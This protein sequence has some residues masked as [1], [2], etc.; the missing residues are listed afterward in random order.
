DG[1]R[2]RPCRR[3]IEYAAAPDGGEL[4]PV[5]DERDP[6]TGLVGD[7]EQGSGG[8]LVEHPGFVDE[9][10]VAGPELGARIGSWAR[11]ASP[12]PVGVPAPSVLV[13]QPGGGV[14]V[15]A[16]LEGGDLRRLQ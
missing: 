9:Q 2:V 7:G 11:P 12:V 3:V 8:V 15:G 6:C 4:V 13:D 16:R 14:A 1:G 5:S 10:Q